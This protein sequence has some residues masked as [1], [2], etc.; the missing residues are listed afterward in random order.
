L[1]SCVG[2]DAL[3]REAFARAAGPEDLSWIENAARTAESRCA[4]R[5]EPAWAIG[6]AS[7]RRAD[8]VGAQAPLEQALKLAGEQSDLVGQA[9]AANRLGSLAYFR[10]EQPRALERF[11]QAVSAAR[12]A[13]RRDLEAFAL[14][15]LAGVYKEIGEFANAVTTF[16]QATAALA[17]SK[18]E[19][20]ARDARANGAVLATALGDFRA[21]LATLEAVFNEAKAAD[22]SDGMSFAALNRAM[23]ELACGEHHK[24][25]EWFERVAA[26]DPYYELWRD[27]GEGRVALELREFARAET[28][29]ERALRA[30]SEMQLA[31]EALL[32]EIALV[33]STHRQGRNQQAKQRITR[34][35][36]AAQKI[37][38]RQ[39]ALWLAEWLLGRIELA[40]GRA[41]S[42]IAAL[43]RSIRVFESQ[44]VPLDPLGEGLH[45]LL[46]RADPYVDLAVALTRAGKPA[47]EVLE[48]IEQ[49]HA[50]ALKQILGKSLDARPRATLERI[51]SSLAPGDLLIDFL[52]GKDH[53]VVW[54]LDSQGRAESH[55]IVGWEQLATP[56]DAYRRALT[57]PLHDL[58]ALAAGLAD[59]DRDWSSGWFLTES[60]LE[61]V[62]ESLR[63]AKRIFIVPDR[64][65]A[66]LPFAALPAQKRRE[67]HHSFLV[68]RVEIVMLPLAGP[69]PPQPTT[70]KPIL[71]AGD[72]IAD[73]E[74]LFPALR[75]ASL[76]LE[77][78]ARVWGPRIGPRLDQGSLTRARFEAVSFEGLGVLHLA[79]HAV[80]S[81]TDPRQCA[82]VFSNGEKL[83]FDRI[84][85]LQFED[86]DAVLSACRTGDGETIPGQGVVGLSWAF[87]LAGARSVTASLWSVDDAAASDL[88]IEFHR[89]L[90]EGHELPHALHRAQSSMRARQPHPAFWAPFVTILRP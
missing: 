64:D 38:S 41:E 13:Q 86:A 43:R 55:V 7:F 46:E 40:M 33:E 11:H 27:Y 68:D 31:S 48:A 17:E 19:K 10:G 30:A 1:T 47:G 77:G 57:R 75:R 35:I 6:E 25:R 83:G 9:C 14:N 29:L 15:N 74:G 28:L 34:L 50:N 90:A 82:L 73:R 8:Y 87:M 61:P 79:T 56:L 5:W 44:S 4:G 20:P 22:D 18:L 49:A 53:G 85:K 69:V 26:G 2:G 45:F 67:P 23:I 66:L 80:A 39:Y 60:L 54:H 12:G 89:Q 65:L 37:D 72:P 63:T 62:G 59:L 78:I 32:I 42:G 3:W 58:P 76:E 36:E 81:T 51:S 70:P 24:A 84:A 16:E 21:A 71:L 88:M 52:I